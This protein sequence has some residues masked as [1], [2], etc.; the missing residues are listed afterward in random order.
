[1]TFNS[2]SIVSIS[3]ANQN[4][5][6]VARLA[7]ENGAAIILKNNAP[8]YVLLEYSCFQDETF[9]DNANVLMIGKQILE[10]HKRAFKELA[11]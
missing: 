1:M 10:K 11:K 4:F 6:K 5:S 2:N 8:R 9:A 3:E 7:S